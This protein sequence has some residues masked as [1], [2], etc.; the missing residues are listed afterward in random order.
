MKMN[1]IN[2]NFYIHGKSLEI[3]LIYGKS[4]EIFIK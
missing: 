1:A 3:F 2:W 4:L